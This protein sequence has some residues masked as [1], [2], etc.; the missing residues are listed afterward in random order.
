MAISLSFKNY[1]K[2]REKIGKSVGMDWLSENGSVICFNYAI[3]HFYSYRKLQIVKLMKMKAAAAAAV[4]MLAVA[5]VT[6]Q[7]QKNKKQNKNTHIK[8]CKVLREQSFVCNT[9]HV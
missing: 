2:R 1:F 7:E 5:A 4:M 8:L 9:F 3:H 6:T